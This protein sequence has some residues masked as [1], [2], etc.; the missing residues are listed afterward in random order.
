MATRKFILCR[1][2]G[3]LAAAHDALDRLRLIEHALRRE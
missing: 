1:R 2:I 3:G